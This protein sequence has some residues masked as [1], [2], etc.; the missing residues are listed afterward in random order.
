MTVLTIS[1]LWDIATLPL[2]DVKPTKKLFHEKTG[3]VEMIKMFGNI[4]ERK[5][6]YFWFLFERTIGQLMAAHIEKKSVKTISKH[7][8][9]E[10][11]A[12][13]NDPIARCKILAKTRR[14]FGR[15]R[16]PELFKIRTKLFNGNSPLMQ[17]FCQHVEKAE[18]LDDVYN[19][20]GSFKWK[21]KK[22]WPESND[23]DPWSWFYLNCPNAQ[24]VRNRYRQVCE[25]Y[26]ETDG[27]K[28][29]SIA[30]GS[31]QPLLHAVVE[32][33][34]VGQGKDIQVILTDTSKDSLKLAERKVNQ[35]GIED[36]TSYVQDS[37]QNLPKLFGN[38]KF[39]VIEACGIIDYLPDRI[40]IKMLRD[41][42]SLLR[43]GG[44]IIVSNM[45]EIF[46]SADILRRVY[47]WELIY[48][49]P[50]QFSRLIQK[51]GGQNIKVYIEP[52]KIHSVAT[53]TK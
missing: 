45:N 38:E 29:L 40:A 19:A 50:E 9:D 39:D 8:S 15:N 47:N 33:L 31:A 18:A 41:S 12:K 3:E 20:L 35:A 10:E 1:K 43:K 48:R 2:T 21:G 28:T 6:P 44:R 13:F 25:L 17:H 42:F 53:A 7:L 27:G 52:W 5:M 46:P 36:I 23:P 34:E 51:A 22:L 4:F 14:N 16:I 49:T 30:C 11:T 37:F 26:K 32:M 24:G